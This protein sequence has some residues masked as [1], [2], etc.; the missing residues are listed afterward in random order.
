MDVPRIGMDEL[1]QIARRSSDPG[2]ATISVRGLT[3]AAKD[4][5][6]GKA[7]PRLLDPLLSALDRRLSALEKT[8]EAVVWPS[9]AFSP[10]T[11]RAAILDPA[12]GKAVGASLPP[13]GS[14]SSFYRFFSGGF[15]AGARHGL[16]SGDYDFTLAFGPNSEDRETLTVKLSPT[17]RTYGAL[18]EK[19]AQ[20]VNQASFP[21]QAS[22]IRQSR[23][24]EKIPGLTQTGTVLALSVE[25]GFERGTLDLRFNETLTGALDFKRGL[26]PTE[27]ATL[28]RYDLVGFQS[29]ERSSFGTKILDPNAPAALGPKIHQFD[30]TLGGRSGSVSVEPVQGE[31]NRDLLNR[32]ADAVNGST[33]AVRARVETAERPVYV[34]DGSGP[35]RIMAAGLGLVLEAV[36]QKLGERLQLKVG[37]P[38]PVGTVLGFFDPSSGLPTPYSGSAYIAQANG[39]GWIKDR[40]YRH[41][42]VSWFETAPTAGDVYWLSS[43]GGSEHFDGSAWSAY[44]A[45]DGLSPLGLDAT[46]TP[47]RDAV[48]DVNGERLNAAT[49]TFS[50]DRDRLLLSLDTSFGTGLPLTVVEGFSRIESMLGDATTAYNEF[51]S[52]LDKNADYLSP[53]IAKSFEAPLAANQAALADLGLGRSRPSGPLWVDG[54]RL[55]GRIFADPAGAEKTLVSPGSGLIPA[56]I[57]AAAELRR[58]GLSGLVDVDPTRPN[59]GPESFALHVKKRLVDLLG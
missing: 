10:L 48:M 37:T 23:S 31:T 34:D 9:G 54:D 47:G 39:S 15:D 51:K 43:T 8:L 35:R 20:A 30:W 13:D 40:V 12:L 41:N 38:E 2:E 56:W 5:Q 6:N 16:G 45:P 18:L 49:G 28:G 1:A 4:R 19:T 7:A 26:V 17:D 27:P 50:L 33:D 24:E 32:L 29:P 11:S 53:R 22:L 14:R 55:V 3:D 58:V 21:V 25:P 59:T 44:T 46:A 36:D 52:L 42:G 57:A